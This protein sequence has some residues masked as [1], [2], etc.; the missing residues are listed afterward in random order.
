MKTFITSVAMAVAMLFAVNANATIIHSTGFE[1]DGA[2]QGVGLNIVPNSIAPFIIGGGGDH[3]GLA[4]QGL[5]S[6]NPNSGS[7]NYVVDAGATFD[8]GQPWGATWAGVNSNSSNSGG[9]LTQATAVNPGDQ[10][11]N[12][13]EG[14][15]FTASA[16][17][18]TD[19]T[20]PL[21]GTAFG[22]V[23]LEFLVNGTE[24]NQADRI[25]SPVTYGST[26]IATGYQL[27]TA[28]Y[29]LTANDIAN[30]INGVNAVL[31]TDGSDHL[32]TDGLIYFDDF[33]FEVDEAFIVTV[34]PEPSSA[35]MLIAGLMGLCGVRRRKS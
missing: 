34:V 17:I 19:S 27:A 32:A 3:V 10:Y 35:S 5:A 2:A 31:G 12:Y 7:Y 20:D 29:S 11:I 26:N 23:R 28:T 25:V 13:A 14:A 24:L 16:L 4:G 6:A 30:G 1:A 21:T 18:A 9:L 22:S 15:T 33:T 8:N